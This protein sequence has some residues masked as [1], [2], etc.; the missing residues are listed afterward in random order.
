MRSAQEQAL[1]QEV[2]EAIRTHPIYGAHRGQTVMAAAVGY[3]SP[4]INAALASPATQMTRNMLERFAERLPDEF[5]WITSRLKAIDYPNQTHDA[6][7]TRA[8]DTEAVDEAISQVE[9]ALE[10]LRAARRRM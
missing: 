7:A 6:G 2:A 4:T 3:S 1:A 10:K 9:S 8:R 5:G